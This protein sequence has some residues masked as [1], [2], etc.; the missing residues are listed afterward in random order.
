MIK[1]IK[2]KEIADMYQLEIEFTLFGL[3]AFN[4][5]QVRKTK[6]GLA[7]YWADM[8]HTVL[9]MNFER[10]ILAC[11]DIAAGEPKDTFVVAMERLHAANKYF[12]ENS[13]NLTTAKVADMI[14]KVQRHMMSV[15]PSTKHEDYDKLFMFLNEILKTCKKEVQ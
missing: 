1:I 8:K 9:I 7:A 2:E 15:L 5:I 10:F 3:P 11:R 4:D 6:E 12:C 13:T 14:I